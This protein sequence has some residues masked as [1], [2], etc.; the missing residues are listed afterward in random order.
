[1]PSI[2]RLFA[3]A[4]PP[5]AAGS[6]TLIT[7]RN[8]S[9]IL[10]AIEIWCQTNLFSG[11][12]GL[13]SVGIGSTKYIFSGKARYVLQSGTPI[14]NVAKILLSLLK[15]NFGLLRR[16]K[17]STALSVSTKCLA[18]RRLGGVL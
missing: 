18:I 4:I 14:R 1:M 17:I 11:I 10:F 12:L 6:S 13:G 15:V 2:S 9:R 5:E 16:Y 8:L 3:A 7:I